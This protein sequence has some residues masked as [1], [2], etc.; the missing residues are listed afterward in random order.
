MSNREFGL[1]RPRS[2]ARGILLVVFWLAI[3]RALAA[4]GQIVGDEKNKFEV[5]IDPGTQH[6][7]VQT[8]E[9]SGSQ[10]PR[11]MSI[12]LFH[13]REHK[14]TIEL[15]AVNLNQKFPRFE[16]ELGP[17]AGSYAGFE[18]SFGVSAKALRALPFVPY[19]PPQKR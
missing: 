1:V 8:L 17:N 18:L 7:A 9:A 15:K 16:G 19:I 5:K 6:V 3:G 13:D 2:S 12:T 4:D 11:K 14:Q 10:K